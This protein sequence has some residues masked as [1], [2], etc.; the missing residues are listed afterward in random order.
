MVNPSL[1][2]RVYGG[3]SI[4]CETADGTD[5][6][7]AFDAIRAAVERARAGN[8]P[9]AVEAVTLRVHGHAAHDD[10][11][12]VPE[13]LRAAD[14]GRAPVER[15]AARLRLDGAGDGELEALRAD[16]GAE[17]ERALAEA[18]ASPAPDP[19]TLEDGVYAS[20]DR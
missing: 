19:G 1:A 8:G 18:E 15:L 20:P 16:V 5:A 9:Q 14:A 2:E 4:P 3:W 13:E 7:A 6:V 10:A 12:Y 17:I 11:R